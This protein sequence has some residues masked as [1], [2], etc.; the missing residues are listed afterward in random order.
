[1]NWC[2]VDPG[3][4]GAIVCWHNEEPMHVIRLEQVLGQRKLMNR[5]LSQTAIDYNSFAV[6]EQVHGIVGD[7]ASGAFNF[8]WICGILHQ[9]F[10]NSIYVSPMKWMHAM[11]AGLPKAMDTKARSYRVAC[12]HYMEFLNNN[13]AHK[14]KDDGIC[15]A[16]LIGKY[17]IKKEILPTKSLTSP[18]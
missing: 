18:T 12:L 17:A 13:N 4:K 14:K 9:Y 10:L 15:D 5:F 3:A 2:S 1:M 11:H 7:S 8:G 6:I 16:L